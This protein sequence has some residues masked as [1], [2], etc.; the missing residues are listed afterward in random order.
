MVVI[1]VIVTVA[2]TIRR[3]TNTSIFA[4]SIK[5]YLVPRKFEGKYEEKK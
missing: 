4:I 2:N 5:L 3:G 1:T